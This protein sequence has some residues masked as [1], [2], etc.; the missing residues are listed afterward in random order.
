M[1]C[2][3]DSPELDYHGGSLHSKIQSRVSRRRGHCSI[4]ATINWDN[5][6]TLWGHF[7][8]YRKKASSFKNV[9]YLLFRLQ[10][11]L[12]FVLF[13]LWIFFAT[14]AIFGSQMVKK[15][16]GFSCPVLL[17]LHD[18][19][20]QAVGWT[21][22]TDFFCIIFG[23]FSFSCPLL[24]T[25]LFVLFRFLSE[26]RKSWNFFSIDPNLNDFGE[27]RLILGRSA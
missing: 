18:H 24:F 19:L 5:R 26:F 1:W 22:Q 16:V 9:N 25:F 10:N 11:A 23:F 20:C 8:R 6:K 14:T 7:G 27:A 12:L 13:L 2:D 17:S 4:Q 15:I 3:S 21:I